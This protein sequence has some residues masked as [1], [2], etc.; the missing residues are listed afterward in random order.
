MMKIDVVAENSFQRKV[1]VSVPAAR[2]RE[3]IEKAYK[4]LGNKV[5]LRGFRKGKTPRKVLEMR[6]R[7]NVQDDV[8]NILVQRGYTS[9]LRDQNIEP[10]SRPAVQEFEPVSADKDFQFTIIVEVRPEIELQSYTGLDVEFP[11]FEV[12]DS[13][14]D[15]MMAS[16]LESEARL[17]EVSR[18]VETGDMVLVELVAKDGDDVVVTEPGTMIRTEADPYYPGVE[19]LLVGLETGGEATG[20][21]SF[22]QNARAQ[23]IAGR[24]LNVTVKVVSVQANQ[25][26]ELTEDVAKE[27]GFDS[28]EAF[29][30]SVS[31]ELGKGREEMGR[32]QAR[33]NLLQALIE[34]NPFE[35]PGGMVEQQL[36]DLIQQLKIQQ[37]YRGIDPRTI[38][39]NDAQMADLRMRAA[40]AAKGG[41]ILDWVSSK[42]DLK[43]TDEDLD[44]HYQEF[45]DERGQ[46]VESIKGYYVK[47]G[48]VE[49]LRGL[50]LEEK[51]LDWLLDRANV[52]RKA[53]SSTDD[54]QAEAAATSDETPAAAGVDLSVLDGGIKDIKAA[55]DSG[56]HDAYLAELLAAEEAGK[57]RAGAIKAIQSRM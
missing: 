19:A 25:V 51:V 34:A 56:A 31:D 12:M 35:V 28:I 2:V 5:S 37:A 26:P 20:S 42:E 18:G 15:A 8:A 22:P 36:G 45:A 24:T 9:A 7:E 30:A 10:V 6:F 29:R 49:Q 57:A 3:E 55:L 38:T 13:E 48:K 16:R 1:Q 11:V 44:T 41:L 33:A 39:F 54:A 47:D 40:F 21:I 23:G 50:L 43:V 4:S 52:I 14:I 32:N 17:V 27:L 53:L 46:T